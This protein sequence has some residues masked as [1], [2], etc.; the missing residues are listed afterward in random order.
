MQPHITNNTLFSFWLHKIIS[1]Y[2]PSTIVE[3]GTY[4]G[5]GSTKII[6]DSIIVNSLECKFFSLE[7]REDFFNIGKINLAQYENFV[8]LLHG[9]VVELEDVTNFITSLNLT[10]SQK[11]F[12]SSEGHFADVQRLYNCK[13]VLSSLPSYIDFLFIDSGEFSAYPEWHTLKS[14]TKI[15]ALDDT[16]VIKCEKIKRELLLDDKYELIVSSDDRQ[17]FAIF[18]LK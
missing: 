18:K 13:N 14:R 1:D 8:T 2:R 6:I 15:V 5:L 16:N 12:L 9:R 3:I 11:Q 4:G 10:E 17:G 7:S